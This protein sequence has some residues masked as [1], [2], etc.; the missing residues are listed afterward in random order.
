MSLLDGM[1]ELGLKEVLDREKHD[2]WVDEGYDKMLKAGRKLLPEAEDGSEV[3][4]FA[5]DMGSEALNKLEEHKGTLV[6]LGKNGLRG[7]IHYVAL[8]M[9]DDATKLAYRL[10][11]KESAGWD[12]IH[13]AIDASSEAG[14]KAKREMDGALDKLL[15][16]LKDI[17]ITLAKAALPLILAAI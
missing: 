15:E 4:V 12:T 9:Y 11:L 17:G 2:K 6:Q 7:T 8:G 13:A 3:A 14:A 10:H 1:V 16:V 5:R